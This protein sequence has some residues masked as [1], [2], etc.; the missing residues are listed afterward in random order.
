MESKGGPGRSQPPPPS[1]HSAPPTKAVLPCPQLTPP[2]PCSP[3]HHRLDVPSRCFTRE[4]LASF[5]R[6]IRPSPFVHLRHPR[7]FTTA[8]SSRSTPPAQSHVSTTPLSTPHEASTEIIIYPIQTENRVGSGRPR[9]CPTTFI[10]LLQC[11]HVRIVYRTVH[12]LL[13]GMF[14]NQNSKKY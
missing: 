7:P 14:T 13:L 4:V 10:V 1:V 11:V 12:V 8:T 3:Q 2:V 6:R 5:I 9:A